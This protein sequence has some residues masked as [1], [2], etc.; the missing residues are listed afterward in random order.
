MKASLAVTSSRLF[1]LL[2]YVTG[3]K[4]LYLID[5]ISDNLP[6]LKTTIHKTYPD[7][8]VARIPLLDVLS[9]R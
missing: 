4:H 5:F 1:P 9:H 6:D 7:V 8:Q 3:A 2:A